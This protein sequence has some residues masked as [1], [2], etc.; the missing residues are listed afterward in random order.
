MLLKTDEMKKHQQK[1]DG[2]PRKVNVLNEPV[3]HFKGT[4]GRK[5]CLAPDSLAHLRQSC[6]EKTMWLVFDN[7]KGK[8]QMSNLFAMP[9]RKHKNLALKYA[10]QDIL[11]RKLTS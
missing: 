4:M 9:C 2:Q 1:R 7:N 3:T 11:L 8:T 5:C 10:A 6:P